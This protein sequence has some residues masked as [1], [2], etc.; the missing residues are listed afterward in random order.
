M[1]AGHG[2]SLHHHAHSV[3]HDLAPEAKVVAVFGFVLA[4]ALTPQD[5]PATYLAHA[6]V[7][8]LVGRAARLPAGFVAKRVLVVLPFVAFAFAI[9]FVAT[10]EQVQVLGLSVSGEGVLASANVLG[11]ALLGATA[12]IILVGTTEPPRILEGLTRLRVPRVLTTIAAFALR[13]VEVLTREVGRMRIAMAARGHDPRWIAQARPMAA[14]AG[15]LF[16]RSYER[17]ERVHAAMSSRGFTGAMPEL[18]D[19]RATATDWIIAMLLPAGAIVVT[20]VARLR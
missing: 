1:G 4:V 14:G 11:K 7:L 18:H 9:P 17:G 2:H 10:G 5:R 6:L 15:A 8:A 16:V 12:S 19:D 20:T 3:V 13:Y